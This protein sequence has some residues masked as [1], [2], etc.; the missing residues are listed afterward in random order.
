MNQT[1]REST[2]RRWFQRSSDAEEERM[3]R[4]K[5]MVEKAISNHAAFRDVN[6]RVYVKGSYAN[7][8]NVRFD[9]DVDVV[10]ENRNVFY[11]DFRPAS[12][13][14]I[15]N[16]LPPYL[17]PW[18]PQRWRQEVEQALK[19]EFTSA[20]VDTS[21]RVAMTVLEVDGSRPSADVVPAFPY[22][23]FD[24]TDMTRFHEGSRVVTTD[25]DHITNYPAQQLANGRAKNVRT[26]R[27]YK[28]FVRALKKAENSL[29]D[30]GVIEELPSYFIECLMWNVP[31]DVIRFGDLFQGFEFAL[32]HIH[33]EMRTT[34][35]SDWEEPN[36]LKRLFAES[37]KWTAEQGEALC[38]RTL[39]YLGYLS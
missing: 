14:P 39:D 12:I 29:A 30:Q 37:S 3:D 22:K 17:G 10:V 31:D 35:G 15:P 5:R 34:G 27:R 20:G 16:P 21:G 6:L 32:L 9:S 23:R 25:G 8:T 19:A 13:A 1:E 36:A 11:Y 33:R 2:L 7:E 4:A 26:G 24:T 28:Q 18:T 38:L